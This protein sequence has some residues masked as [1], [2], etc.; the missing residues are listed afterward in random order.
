MSM[1]VFTRSILIQHNEKNTGLQKMQKIKLTFTLSPDDTI[2]VLMMCFRPIRGEY[3]GW[4][5]CK[6]GERL[7]F[8]SSALNLPLL[9]GDRMSYYR[10]KQQKRK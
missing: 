2:S 6:A 8:L 3:L 9:R 5:Y 1:V 4:Q 7:T 10:I